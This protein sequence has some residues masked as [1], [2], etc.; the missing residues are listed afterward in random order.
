MN[1]K[2]IDH[3]KEIIIDSLAF[4]IFDNPDAFREN[5]DGK[6]ISL[7]LFED[8][9]HLKETALKLLQ[10]HL[11]ESNCKSVIGFTEND[12]SLIVLAT[13][14][15]LNE[16]LPLYLYDLENDEGAFNQFIRRPK[17]IPCSLIIPYSINE[18]HVFDI[19]EMFSQQKIPISKVISIIDENT[20]KTNFSDKDF[21]FV[22]I[23]DWNS[24]KN[25]MNH[26]QNITKEKMDQLLANFG[27]LK[28]NTSDFIP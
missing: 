13:Q 4:N 1:S 6:H 28:S 5:T 24:L 21:E 2:M 15:S 27:Y 22:S 17:V 14:A 20:S 16:N 7:A 9:K 3:T 26:Y 10:F 18:K 11:G 19:I 23:C 25:R 12:P 8:P